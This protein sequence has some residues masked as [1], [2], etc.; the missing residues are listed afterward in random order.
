MLA[1]EH[2]INS[3]STDPG[4][5]AS[6][7]ETA[8]HSD[9]STT[10]LKSSGSIHHLRRC[11]DGHSATVL[12]CS[13]LAQEQGSQVPPDCCFSQA[14]PQSCSFSLCNCCFIQAL[15]M[16]ICSFPLSGFSSP[17]KENLSHSSLS[18]CPTWSV[19][20]LYH[21]LALWR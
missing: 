17:S 16:Q 7:H 2:Q 8:Q 9:F 11:V 20:L 6:H 3:L 10:K 14:D 15:N 12:L 13:C 19:L 4:G 1:S 18:L 21:L 5:A